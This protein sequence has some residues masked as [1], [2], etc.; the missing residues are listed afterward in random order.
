MDSSSIWLSYGGRPPG[1]ICIAVKEDLNYIHSDFK[2]RL[3]PSLNWTQL[4]MTHF[5]HV[6]LLSVFF[7]ISAYFKEKT[8]KKPQRLTFVSLMANPSDFKCLKIE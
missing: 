7:K 3:S 6:H 1:K 8:G 2:Y 4:K 5:F